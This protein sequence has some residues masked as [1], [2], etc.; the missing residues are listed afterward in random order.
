MRLS[1]SEVE[2]EVAMSPVNIN[3]DVPHPGGGILGDDALFNYDIWLQYTENSSLIILRDRFRDQLTMHLENDAI[4]GSVLVT[5]LV[6][7]TF[8]FRMSK[9]QKMPLSFMLCAYISPTEYVFSVN[10]YALC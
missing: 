9:L 10:L 4:T 7:F 6:R 1:D 3:S 8:F 2:E 5:K